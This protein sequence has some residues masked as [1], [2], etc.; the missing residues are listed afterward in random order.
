VSVSGYIMNFK[1][2]VLVTL[3]QKHF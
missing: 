2:V 1:F 3:N